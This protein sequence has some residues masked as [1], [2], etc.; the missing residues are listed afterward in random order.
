MKSIA[1]YCGSSIGASEEYR[2]GAIDLGKEIARR[3]I[4]LV[5]GGASVGL[6]GVIADTVLKE[7]GEA[8]GVIPTVLGD[9]EIAHQQ[10]TTLYTVDSMH[11]RKAK[12]AELAD[13]FI[14]MPGGPGTM[15]EFFEMFT[16]AQIG[17][18][19]KPIGL[20]NLHHYYDPMSHL[21]DH[22][23]S[24]GFMQQANRDLAVITEHPAQLLDQLSRV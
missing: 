3:G 10:L 17:I 2:Q 13:G 12:M 18:H 8:I 16:W 24:E 1:V 14:A 7:G 21:L 11:E 6:M 9:K 23:V 4:T 19:Q 20:L 22:M 15:E 5:Y